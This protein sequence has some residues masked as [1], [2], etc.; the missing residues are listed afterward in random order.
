MTLDERFKIT[1]IPFF[2]S[3]FNLLIYELDHFTFESFFIGIILKQNKITILS[4]FPV[5]NLKWFLLVLQL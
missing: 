3:N 4:R 5:K 1:S 2:I